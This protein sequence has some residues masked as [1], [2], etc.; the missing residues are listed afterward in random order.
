MKKST[1]TLSKKWKPIEQPKIEG[2]QTIVS[3][4]QELNEHYT[5]GIMSVFI[6]AIVATTVAADTVN[7]IDTTT[8]IPVV[9]TMI[10]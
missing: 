9:A 5:T 6:A 10:S 1:K 7:I 8:S 3:I 2:C 4:N